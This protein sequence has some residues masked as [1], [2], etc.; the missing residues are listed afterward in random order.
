[1]TES[2][3]RKG[4]QKL[5]KPISHNPI[6]IHTQ[7]AQQTIL[8]PVQKSDIEA[9]SPNTNEFADEREKIVEENTPGN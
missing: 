2:G 1:M 6:P 9:N 4:K 3:K 7:I 5:S 8:E